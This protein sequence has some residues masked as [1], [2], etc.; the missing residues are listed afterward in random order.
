MFFKVHFLPTL[1]I[2]A[3]ESKEIPVPKSARFYR[4]STH[5]RAMDNIPLAVL[6][7]RAN[8]TQCIARH[9]DKFMH[10]KV[11][12]WCGISSECIFCCKMLFA[13]TFSFFGS[14]P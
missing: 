8:E 6:G 13:P 9:M 4:L 7:F 12:Q 3:F 5:T 10:L 11:K 1:P 14:G 2:A